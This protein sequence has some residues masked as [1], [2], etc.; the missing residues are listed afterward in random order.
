MKSPQQF[1]VQ[2]ERAS[3]STEPR[4]DRGANNKRL[5]CTEAALVAFSVPIVERMPE[6][7]ETSKPTRDGQGV[8]MVALCG[9]FPR[10]YL[11]NSTKG[12]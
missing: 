9:Q 11:A 5:P 10:T 2:K 7:H 4:R 1:P 8:P 6:A 12:K 3:R